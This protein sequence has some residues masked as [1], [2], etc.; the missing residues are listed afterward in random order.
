[1]KSASPGKGLRG[2]SDGRGPADRGVLSEGREGLMGGEADRGVSRVGMIV[3]TVVPVAGSVA[4]SV[5]DSVTDSVTGSIDGSITGLIARSMAGSIVDD[6]EG[7]TAKQT[8]RRFSKSQMTVMSR[9]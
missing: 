8:R 6:A 5:A 4:G 9:E 7:M 2:S 1:M 3:S